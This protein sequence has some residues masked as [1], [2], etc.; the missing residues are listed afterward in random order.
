MLFVGKCLILVN[1]AHCA[2]ISRQVLN[3]E[4][5]NMQVLGYVHT[6]WSGHLL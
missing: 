1:S 6:V 4:L 2:L 3:F 5:S